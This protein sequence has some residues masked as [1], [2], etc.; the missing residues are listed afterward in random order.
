MYFCV[1][2]CAR[3]RDYIHFNKLV[4]TI[5]KH[6]HVGYVALVFKHEKDRYSHLDMAGVHLQRHCENLKTI[7]IHFVPHPIIFFF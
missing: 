5:Y 4:F 1:R 3:K 7:T 6:V 2:L